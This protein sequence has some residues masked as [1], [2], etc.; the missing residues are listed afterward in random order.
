MTITR[1][2]Q[3]ALEAL[4]V[5]DD[6]EKALS[7]D[8]FFA[9]GGTGGDTGDVIAS[10]VSILD[11]GEFYTGTDVEAALQEIGA[12]FTEVNTKANILSTTPP[13]GSIAFATNT[14][15]LLIYDGTTW[16]EAPLSLKTRGT[17]VD[18]GIFN[19]TNGTYQ[20][21]GDSKEQGYFDDAI[22]NKLIS[23]SKLSEV[24]LGDN[25]TNVQEGAI[26]FNNSSFQV[27]ANA[28]W[29]DI[30]INF[31]FRED[32]DG[33]YE[34]EHK[35]IGF[36]LWYEVNSGNSNVLGLD[37]LPVIQQYNSTPGIYGSKLII[38]GG[39]F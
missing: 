24:V 18:M 19:D 21:F 30:V 25:T 9:G 22:F 3:Q 15:E 31:R 10:E 17:G 4:G 23:F 8:M 39:G 6:I 35:P 5:F 38:D 34:L 14:K 29:N 26:R 36:N 11:T 16:R 37:G 7:R 20:L 2:V 12:R 32:P 27:Y 1:E 13:S 28:T 33:N